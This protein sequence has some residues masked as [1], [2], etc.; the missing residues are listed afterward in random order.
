MSSL[1]QTAIQTPE[2]PLEFLGRALPRVRLLGAATPSPEHC[3]GTQRLLGVDY[4]TALCE[5][6]GIREQHVREQ[7]TSLACEL[8][9]YVVLD[10][11]VRDRDVRGGPAQE[12]Q[13]VL[14][15]LRASAVSRIATLGCDGVALWNHYTV[16]YEEGNSCFLDMRPDIAVRKRCAF[17]FLPLAVPPIRSARGAAA[18]GEFVGSYLFSLQL[19]DDFCDLREDL[20]SAHEQ[21][22]LLHCIDVESAMALGNDRAL[23]AA[24][25]VRYASEILA[26]WRSYPFR[27]TIK[28]YLAGSCSWLSD[29][30][31][32]LPHVD[33]AFVRSI[34]PSA[35]E[36]LCFRSCSPFA[37]GGLASEAGHS[38]FLRTL[39]A[40]NMHAACHDR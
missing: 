12:L 33:A 24:C 6:A 8:R 2:T 9:A 11:F 26:P 3:V 23:L 19:L 38:S 13:Q 40:E 15:E 39:C 35:D 34:F 27:R 37:L 28:K 22:L 25:V 20:A 7:L 10:D 14:L 4:G 17:V 1:G 29:A 36:P 32:Q 16:Q 18:L 21:N 30:S 31:M 5:E